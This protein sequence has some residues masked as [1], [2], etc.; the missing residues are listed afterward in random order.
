MAGAKAKSGGARPGSGGSRA[1][2]GRKPSAKTIFERE[3]VGPRIPRARVRHATDAD[4]AEARRRK[5]ANRA[6]R[7]SA[8]RDAERQVLGLQK[9]Q[10][11]TEHQCA[12]RQCGKPFVAKLARAKFCTD[13]CRIDHGNAAAKAKAIDQVRPRACRECSV[14]FTP[15]YGAKMKLF[16]GESCSVAHKAK[17]SQQWKTAR[18]ESDPI[19]RLTCHMR[20]FINNALRRAGCDK[21]QRTQDILGC[22]LPFFRRHIERQFKP[23]MSW[24]RRAEWHIDHIIPM[25]T[26]TSMTDAVRLNHF[27]NLRPMWARDNLIKG[28]KVLA[29]L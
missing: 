29:L 17:Q 5:D 2:A 6:A 7:Q 19:Y 10:R 16:C 11:T 28:A 25:A 1:G 9:Y 13:Q 8:A 24:E 12:C 4:R 22:E 15:A 18:Q 23:G 26:A 21:D 27:S 14:E 3:F 20:T